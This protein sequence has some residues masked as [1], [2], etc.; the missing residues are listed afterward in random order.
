MILR[1]VKE[2]MRFIVHI[3][4]SLIT[5]AI[6]ALFIC[7][8]T[9]YLTITAS[10]CAAWMALGYAASSFADKICDIIFD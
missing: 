3:A 4:V 1:K 5:I 10:E 2:D 6:Y 9:H 8:L 7:A